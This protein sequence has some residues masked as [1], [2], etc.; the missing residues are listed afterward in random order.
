MDE[1]KQ[2]NDKAKCLHSFDKKQVM[3]FI[4]YVCGKCGHQCKKLPQFY[5]TY[6]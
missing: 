2:E 3:G 1:A 5:S 6:R 4:F